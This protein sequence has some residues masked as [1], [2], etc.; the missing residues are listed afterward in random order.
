MSGASGRQVTLGAAGGG[1]PA[2]GGA[3]VRL[4]AGP[5]SMEEATA[6]VTADGG[7]GPRGVIGSDS[8]AGV[9]RIRVV[10]RVQV[11]VGRVR[12][13]ARVQV[14]VGR[15]RVVARVQVGV[16]RVRIA[17]RVRLAV[18]RVRVAR[19]V[20]LAVGRLRVARRVRLAVGRAWV[21]LAV[22]VTGPARVPRCAVARRQVRVPLA[23]GGG[24]ADQRWIRGVVE[25]P[26]A[27]RE[28][29]GSRE[30]GRAGVEPAGRQVGRVLAPAEW[31]GGPAVAGEPACGRVRRRRA[32]TAAPGTQ[33]EAGATTSAEATVALR[34]VLSE[35][36]DPLA[37]FRDRARRA[38]DGR[39]AGPARTGPRL[40]HAGGGRHCRVRVTPGRDDG[41]GWRVAQRGEH[42]WTRSARASPTGT[43]LRPPRRAI[44]RS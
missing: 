19:R 7:P 18:G 25:V 4:R 32:A 3:V 5:R 24:T 9:R 22:G 41:V 6:D 13:V 34:T 17:S 16:G 1:G 14:G 27:P 39:R 40:R 15:V 29:R 33:P 26:V 20:R 36:R 35:R 42:S 2:V 12:V 38:R 31:T 30:P 28:D 8:R 37:A 23:L 21:R 44:R 11:G 10:A 43:R